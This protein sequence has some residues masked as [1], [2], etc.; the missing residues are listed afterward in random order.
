V[1]IGELAIA[2]GNPFGYERTVTIG[3]VSGRRAAVETPGGTGVLVDA[4][5]TDASINPGNSG[6]PLLN[7]RGEVIGVNTL[8][9]LIQGMGQA[10]INFAI[11]V[12]A[13]KRIAP[14]LIAGGT[15][16]HPFLGVGAVAITESIATE[17]SLP[18]REGLIVQSVTPGSGAAAAGIRPSTQA[19]QVRSRELG[20]GGD[21]IVAVDGQPMR[22]SPDLLVY[23]ERSRQPGDTVTVTVNRDGQNQDIPVRVGDRPPAPR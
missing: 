13:V 9:R 7:G 5:Q 12:N 6:G 8:A 3:I 2:I 22:S 16:S 23:L 17:L 15:Y 11:P 1:E 14:R 10:G 21:I 19:R 4:I 20:V 18:V